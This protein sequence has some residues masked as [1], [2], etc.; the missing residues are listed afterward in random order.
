[1]IEVNDAI[2]ASRAYP[3]AKLIYLDPPFWPGEKKR[4]KG[5]YEYSSVAD[6]HA[7]FLYYFER[8]FHNIWEIL[9]QDGAMV[10][11]CDWHFCHRFRLLGDEVF[12]ID[13]FVN[14]VVWC[15]TGPAVNKNSFPKKHDD[16]L[17]WRKS[18]E[19]KPN[20]I[21]VPYKGKLRVGGKT[22]WAGEE[23]DVEE[24]LKRGK[25][26]EDWWAD[27]KPL[28]ST[29]KE[30][31]GYPDQKPIALLERIINF[32]TNPGDLVVDLFV[33][34][35]T[36]AVAAHNL[37]RTFRGCDIYSEAVELAKQRVAKLDGKQKEEK[38]KL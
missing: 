7:T 1:M 35:G 22:S 27:I 11:H 4:K 37:G 9:D 20:M 16:I 2:V 31:V 13:N 5:S 8:L 10:V 3:K 29:Q 36:T 38:A 15:Y 28:N 24:Y 26:L 14:H 23:K 18:K 17:I 12:G 19:F 32:A 30:K 6:T 33:G 21:R 34:S 25:L